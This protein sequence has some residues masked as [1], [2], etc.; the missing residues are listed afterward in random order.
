LVRFRIVPE[1]L[2]MCIVERLVLPDLG[3]LSLRV[4]LGLLHRRQVDILIV[5]HRRIG[6]DRTCL[7]R[8]QI[9]NACT[10]RVLAGALEGC[11]LWSR[12]T[13]SSPPPA[14]ITPL[15]AGIAA[16]DRP[17]QEQ[18]RCDSQATE[19]REPPGGWA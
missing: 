9:V 17:N 5:A 15:G 4:P 14:A 12:A 13:Q 18:S 19:H 7:R 16:R 11:A 8:V 3:V 10:H 2:L 6:V 1:F